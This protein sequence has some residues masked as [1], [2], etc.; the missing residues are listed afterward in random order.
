MPFLSAID[1]PIRNRSLVYMKGKVDKLTS[2]K[3]F[4]A[5]DAILKVYDRAGFKVFVETTSKL[6]LYACIFLIF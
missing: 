5:I 2:N 6:K 1:T 3:L 4:E